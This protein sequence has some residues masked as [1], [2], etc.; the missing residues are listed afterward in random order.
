MPKKRV[1]T[2]SVRFEKNESIQEQT[3]NFFDLDG[4]RNTLS[5][6]FKHKLPV[7]AESVGGCFEGRTKEINWH[8]Q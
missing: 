4:A 6:L 5:M 2:L 3:G 1:I 8:I 7:Y